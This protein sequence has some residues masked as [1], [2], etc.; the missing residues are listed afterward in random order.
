VLRSI[1]E[2]YGKTVAQVILRWLTQKGI[3]AIPK[4]VRRERMKEN[5]SIFDFELTQEDMEKIATLDEGQSAFFSHRDPEVVKWIC[6]L[7]R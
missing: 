2:K 5:I 7:K 4:T 1:A 6:S 3:V